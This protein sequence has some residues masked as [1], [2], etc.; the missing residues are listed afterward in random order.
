MSVKQMTTSQ[1]QDDLRT[2]ALMW[3]EGIPWE[4]TDRVNALKGELKRRGEPFEK[5]VDLFDERAVNKPATA[6][7]TDELEAELR[8]LSERVARNPKD[9]AAQQ[10][11][12]DVR[13]ELR[14]RSRTSS[15]PA[16]QP[17][18][19]PVAPRALELPSDDEVELVTP[20]PT[21]AR[22][23][24]RRPAENRPQPKSASPSSGF[25]ASGNNG[26]VAVKFILSS[27]DGIVRVHRE[28]TISQVD[29]LIT[30]LLL[31]RG[32]AAA[33]VTKSSD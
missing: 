27:D 23:V 15:E 14:Q 33:D 28:L 22:I 16:A 1:I 31:A 13:Y 11:F 24:P 7:T 3:P 5:P 29:T 4:Q 25:D 6:A 18:T 8:A 9:E 21:E 2:I 12:A 19:S 30:K 10:R 26:Y 17:R 20:P 32:E